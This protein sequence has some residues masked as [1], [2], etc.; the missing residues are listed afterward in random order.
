MRARNRN[1]CIGLLVTVLLFTAVMAVGTVF[2]RFQAEESQP[3]VFIPS[4][5]GTVYLGAV[6]TPDEGSV[7]VFDPKESINGKG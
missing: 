1:I 4:A 7:P 6:A 3:L 5:P 2:A